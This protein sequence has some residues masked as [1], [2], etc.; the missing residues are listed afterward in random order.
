MDWTYAVIEASTERPPTDNISALI[1]ESHEKIFPI[2]T[3]AGRAASAL[4]MITER[5]GR[6]EG[7]VG[8][9]PTDDALLRQTEGVLVAARKNLQA[10]GRVST[11]I[12]ETSVNCRRADSRHPRWQERI[13]DAAAAGRSDPRRCAR[14]YAR[15]RPS[16]K[17]DADYRPKFRGDQRKPASAAAVNPSERRAA[18][19][20]ADQL[21]GHWL[22]GSGGAS[23][24]PRR[25]APTQARP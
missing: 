3:D 6:G 5:I 25:L 22:L 19:K 12:V 23:P 4:A 15:P 24:E 11:H 9:V 10:L 20:I 17:A 8:R 1:D 21:R 18:R 14:C 2:L 16:Y 7:N 13:P